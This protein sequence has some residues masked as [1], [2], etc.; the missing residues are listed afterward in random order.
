MD[1]GAR[2]NWERQGI[3]NGWAGRSEPTR[4]ENS[5]DMWN[6]KLMCTRRAEST[7]RNI[8]TNEGRQIWRGRGM[9]W[10]KSQESNFEVNPSWD[11]K[12]VEVFQKGGCAETG[13]QWRCFKRGAVLDRDL[14]NVTTRASVF[15]ILCMRDRF[16]FDYY[17]LLTAAWI[18]YFY[19][20]C[21]QNKTILIVT[22]SDELVQSRRNTWL[23]FIFQC[24]SSF[25]ILN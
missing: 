3:P 16:L 14:E 23:I 25:I 20:I 5:A 22:K 21:E 15:W 11:W 18:K 4:A 6:T 17:Y 10:L 13:S 1:S 9:E 19:N 12:P 7:W 8:R 2:R 24:L